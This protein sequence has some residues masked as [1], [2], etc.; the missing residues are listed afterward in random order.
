MRKILKAIYSRFIQDKQF[1]SSQKIETSVR[2]TNKNPKY[3]QYAIGDWT[4]GNPI[5]KTWDK[6]TK[7]KIGKFCSLAG[8]V[9]LLL[10]GEHRKDW[11][12]TYPFSEFFEEARNI[13]GHPHTK[14]NITIGNDVWICQ[15]AIILSG[16]TIGNGAVIGAG[17]LVT[18]DVPA[19]AIAAGNPAHIVG[20]RFSKEQIFALEEIAW[21]DWDISQVNAEIEFLLSSDIDTFINRHKKYQ[22]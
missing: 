16:V 3:A 19:Y 4:Y 5:I 10:G 9:Q 2:F 15:N 18:K 8:N 13:E 21:W 11:V 14:G 1:I 17:C 6:K 20:Y 22:I 12:T 7:L